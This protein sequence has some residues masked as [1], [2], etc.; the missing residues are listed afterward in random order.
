MNAE[1]FIPLSQGKVAVVDFEDFE[2]VRGFSW[3]ADRIHNTW[4]AATHIGKGRSRKVVRMHRFLLEEKEGSE[5]DHKDGDGLNNRRHNLRSCSHRQNLSNQKKQ[6]GRSSSFKGVSLA[7]TGK[8][9]AQLDSTHLGYF[10]TEEAAA[11]TYDSKAREV[12]GEFAK[13]NFP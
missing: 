13:L 6:S 11:R 8:W 1:V 12:F 9:R 7:S 2:K 3:Y 4:Y 5:V 10:D